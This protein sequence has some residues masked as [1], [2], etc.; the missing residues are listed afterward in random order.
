MKFISHIISWVLMPILMP[1]YAL[2][3]V[4]FFP[5]EPINIYSNDS[6]F[7]IPLQNKIVLLI[8]YFIF[9]VFAPGMLYIYLKKVKLISSLEMNE[10]NERK[11]PMV[12][13]SISCLFLYYL[14][15]S[16][17]FILPKYI[18]GLC[19]SGAVI[20]SLFTLLN[21]YLKVSLHATGVGILSGFVLAYFA[22]QIYFEIWILALSFFISGLVLT[23][24][25]YLEK[26]TPKEI[27]IGYFFSFIVTFILNLYYPFG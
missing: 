5:S 17:N 26:H 20:I 12:I 16:N 10:Q 7:L 14:L 21:L 1:I 13:M 6:L 27:I 2:L 3:L 19:L 8:Y 15:T 9:S 23:S 18:Y 25:L 24:R 22:E 4:M 11:I